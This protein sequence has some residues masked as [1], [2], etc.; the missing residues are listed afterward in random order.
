MHCNI[1]GG[2]TFSQV[3]VLWDE[4]VAEWGI[5]NEER[6]YI[7]RQQGLTCEACGTNIRGMALA[8]AITDHWH[9]HG[10]FKDFVR[11]F[12]R[13]NVL[14]INEAGTLTKPLGT[15]PGR[16][17]AEYPSVDI[18]DLSY[19]DQSFDLVVHSD[20][21]EHVEN[22]ILALAECG[23]VLRPGGLLAFTVPVIV[24]RMTRSRKGLA[25]SYHG[26][27]ETGADD[28]AVQ[29]EYGADMWRHVIAAGFD[30]VKINTFDYPAGIAMSATK[31]RQARA[32]SWFKRW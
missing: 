17:L 4:L 3:A 11:K 23:R 8:S 27:P 16:V 13:L 26:F 28:W 22:P 32:R 14:E 24:D 20:T 25:K 15:L 31:R 12:S 5:S 29:T 6:S 18:H 30:A 21:L 19:S 7:D 2:S 9:F 1:C 10:L